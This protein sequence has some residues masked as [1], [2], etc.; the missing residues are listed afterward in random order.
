VE[1]QHQYLEHSGY[2][3]EFGSRELGRVR[4][5]S[6]PKKIKGVPVRLSNSQAVSLINPECTNSFGAATHSERR[7]NS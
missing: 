5:C 7:F 2:E 6:L 1:V 3:A 4:L